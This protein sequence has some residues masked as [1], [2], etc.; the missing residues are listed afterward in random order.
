MS[1][2]TRGIEAEARPGVE[3]AQPAKLVELAAWA[4]TTLVY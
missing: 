4:E 1:S 3:L 2:C